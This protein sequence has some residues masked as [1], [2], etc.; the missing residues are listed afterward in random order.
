MFFDG[1]KQQGIT[2]AEIDRM[3]KE[4]RLVSSGLNNEGKQNSW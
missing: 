3:A 2:Q 1:L 4:I